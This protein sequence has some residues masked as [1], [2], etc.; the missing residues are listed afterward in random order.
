MFHVV[1]AAVQ[2]IGQRISNKDHCFGC[3]APAKSATPSCRAQS[4]R[5]NFFDFGM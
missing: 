1:N 5:P 2:T 3:A 4:L